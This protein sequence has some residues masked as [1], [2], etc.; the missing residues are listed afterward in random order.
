[1]KKL[2]TTA[3]STVAVLA[4][5]STSAFATDGSITFEGLVTSDTC[6]VSVNGASSSTT[7]TL[8]PVAASTLASAT[9]TSGAMPF[10]IALSQCNNPT[11][12]VYAFFE[13][14]AANVSENG[15]LNNV[16]GTAA[17]VTLQ[18]KD[19][20]G[21]VINI[22]NDDQKANPFTQTMVNGATTLNY[23][24]EYFAEEAVTPGTVL[25]SVTYAINY[26]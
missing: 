11:G 9:K 21:S 26:I 15:R 22:G 12:T 14:N 19:E 23:S 1:M 8:D 5:L 3:L 6:S 4:A 20:G 17:N 2:A 25:T 10:T 24:V 16:S 13:P 7:V 18:L